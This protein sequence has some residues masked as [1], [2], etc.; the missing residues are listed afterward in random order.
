MHTF[1]HITAFPCVK[2]PEGS[3]KEAYYALYHMRAYVRDHHNLALPNSLKSWAEHLAM[4]QDKDLRAEF[5]RIQ[6][7]F[8]TIIFQDVI[9]KGG[10][11]YTAM[12]PSNAE[13]DKRL[14]LQGDDRPF[15]LVGGGIRFVPDIGKSKC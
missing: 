2:Q 13:I 9:R 5:Y 3:Q 12:K 7:Q 6:E 4:I 15:L 8:A 1:G 14:L 10:M 11:F